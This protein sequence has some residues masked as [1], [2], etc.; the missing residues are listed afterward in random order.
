MKNHQILYQHKGGLDV[1]Q[2]L[3][4]D[5]AEPQDGEV[6]V[7]IIACGVAFADILMRL[8]AYPG[9]PAFP[10]TPGYD[11]VGR[12]ISSGPRCNIFKPGQFVAALTVRGAY[13]AYINLPQEELV[14]LPNG[15]DPYEASASILNYVTAWQMLQRH[16]LVQNGESILVHGAAGGVGTAL[17][18]LAALSGL[19]VFGTA[20]HAKHD[21]VS[22]LGATPIDYHSEDFVSRILQVTRGRGVD[23]VFDGVGGSNLWRSARALRRGGKLIGYGFL[24]SY[25]QDHINNTQTILTFG[26]MPLIMLQGKRVS[27]YS[28][29]DEKKKDLAAFKNDLSSIFNLLKDHK[30]NPVIGARFPL[31]QAAEAQRLLGSAAVSGK[32]ILTCEETV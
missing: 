23:V 7:Q 19:K 11:L 1:I 12:V 31:D 13:A 28:I 15:V 32:I 29:G 30:I 20:S 16:A 5:L 21:L 25:N 10:F 22:S 17:L 3:D 6:C 18:Q 14:P 8:G 27:F 24:Q 26:M 2:P 4:L 9:A